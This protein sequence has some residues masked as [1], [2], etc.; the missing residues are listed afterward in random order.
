M[1]VLVMSLL[2]TGPSRVPGQKATSAMSI[3]RKRRAR[4][5]R[6]SPGGKDQDDAVPIGPLALG[7]VQHEQGKDGFQGDA[8]HRTIRQSTTVKL[9]LLRGNGFEPDQPCMSPMRASFM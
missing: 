7:S 1:P 6:L 4:P 3:F 2:M 9:P 5:T 8:A